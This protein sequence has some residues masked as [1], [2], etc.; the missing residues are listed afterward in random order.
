MDFTFQGKE[1]C[2]Q[3]NK[4]LYW[5]NRGLV[6]S[7]HEDRVIRFFDANSGSYFNN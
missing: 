3:T 2:S 7:G 4:L 6:V 1:A 5:Q